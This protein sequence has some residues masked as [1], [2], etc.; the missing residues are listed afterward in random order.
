M[1]ATALL[2]KN[3]RPS[4]A[5][6]DAAM[7]GN[8]CRCGTYQRVREAIKS[9]SAALG[10]GKKAEDAHGTTRISIAPP[11]P[12]ILRRARRRPGHR[13]LAARERGRFAFAQ[14]AKKTP[15]HPNAFLRIGKDGTCTVMVKHLEFGRA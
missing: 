13:V 3:P 14:E 11:F 10:K 6:I 1:S 5:D 2:A 8:I 15:I 12:A 4:D 9:A 7:S